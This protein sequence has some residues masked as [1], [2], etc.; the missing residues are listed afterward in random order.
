[1]S[2]RPNALDAHHGAPAAEALTTG[3]V[4]AAGLPFGL[5]MAVVSLTVTRRRS[6]RA[7]IRASDS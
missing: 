5:T 4:A 7:A 2:P 1:M 6:E 3:H